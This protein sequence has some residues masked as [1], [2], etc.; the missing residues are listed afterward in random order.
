MKNDYVVMGDL[1]TII[2]RSKGEVWEC[3]ID[4][5][6]LPRVSQY[7]WW[8]KRSK[9]THYAMATVYKSKKKHIWLHRLIMEPK[10]VKE[11]VDHINHNGLDNTKR[12][13]RIV[14][15]SVNLRNRRIAKGIQGV[16]NTSCGQYWRAT[17]SLDGKQVHLGNF[18]T[19][20]EAIAARLAAE[21]ILEKLGR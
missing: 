9:N 10:S 20:E 17:M 15:Q 11:V 18:N 1:T 8:L 21:K 6:D 3:F 4:T 2:I 5:E 12:N 13:L 14:S 19:E 7:S 16:H